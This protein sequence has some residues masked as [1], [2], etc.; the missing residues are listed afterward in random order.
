MTN[1][2]IKHEGTITEMTDDYVRVRIVQTSACKHCRI[3]GHCNASESKVKFVDVERTIAHDS[4]HIG[5][6]VYVGIGMS[7]AGKALLWAF[8][9]P[10]VCVVAVLVI[11]LQLTGSEMTAGVGAL[12]SL[13]P[14]YAILYCVRNVMAKRISF[15]IETSTGKHNC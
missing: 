3:A 1:G 7:S 14:Y 15:E 6:S 12:A 10:F 11:L 4:L 13:V 5:D 9:V 8:G 2:K